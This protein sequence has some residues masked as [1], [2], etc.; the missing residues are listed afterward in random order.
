MCIFVTAILPPGAD[1]AAFEAIAARHS[2]RLLPQD[3]PGLHADLAEGERAYLTTPGH[4]DCDTA[5]GSARRRPEAPSPEERARRL[6]RKGWSEGKIARALEQADA[7][8]QDAADATGANEA[9]DLSRWL[10]LLQQ[11]VRAGKAS[12]VGLLFHM[13]D[14]S[15]QA[16]FPVHGRTLHRLSSVGADALAHLE[17]DTVHVFTNT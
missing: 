8:R 3:N 4:C 1:H 9:A 13:Y 10:S 5:L 2:R 14:G 15:L 17:P 7:H 11:W 12:Y 16:P 6:R